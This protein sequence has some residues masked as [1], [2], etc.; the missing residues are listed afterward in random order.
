MRSLSNLIKSRYVY[1]NDENKKIIDSNGK[2]EV[3]KTIQFNRQFEAV[4]QKDNP[5]TD[6]DT[7]MDND[8]FTE[9]LNVTVIDSVVS[10]EEINQNRLQAEQII[11]DAN[12][13][14]SKILANAEEEAKSLSQAAME[15]ARQKGY[16]EGMQ[17]GM[18][19]VEQLK[20]ELEQLRQRQDKDYLNQIAKLE[21]T[22]GDIVAEL[23]ERITGVIVKDKKDVILYL[24][25]NSIIEADNSKSYTI[26]VSRD[27][28]ELVLSKKEELYDILPKDAVMD[29][30]LDKNLSENQCLIE[31]DTRMI[32]CSLDVQLTNLIQDIKLVSK[33]KE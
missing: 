10:E 29:I 28:Y 22:F 7:D 12:E 27:E 20:A 21:P 25:H 30:I 15:E 24:L 2:S 3:L 1:V 23:V 26:R 16:E 19:E 9:G 33:Q 31:T 18:S 6:T 17:K 11:T 14:A 4:S 5:I 32:D 8:V 13:Q